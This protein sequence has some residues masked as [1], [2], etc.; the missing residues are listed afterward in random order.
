MRCLYNAH[1]FRGRDSY[2]FG[3]KENVHAGQ[4]RFLVNNESPFFCMFYM[5][6]GILLRILLIQKD[7]NC[8]LRY[9]MSNFSK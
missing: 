5:D 7:M 1:K 6:N 8:T 4:G 9:I 3:R 2:F